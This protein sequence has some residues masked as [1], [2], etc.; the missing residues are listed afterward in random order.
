MSPC[1]WSHAM[2]DLRTSLRDLCGSPDQ[3]P[4]T[5]PISVLRIVG[6]WFSDG[7]PVADGTG[8]LFVRKWPGSAI[9]NRA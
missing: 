7:G 5:A 8:V 4:R 9:T 1:G 3:I 6:L 2:N